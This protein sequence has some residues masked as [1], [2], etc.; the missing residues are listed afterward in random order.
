VQIQ[1]QGEFRGRKGR[2]REIPRGKYFR[3]LRFN[4]DF[5]FSRLGIKL[6]LD[7][8]K[9]IHKDYNAYIRADLHNKHNKMFDRIYSIINEVYAEIHEEDIGLGNPKKT[10]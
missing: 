4:E 1:F 8:V 10:K 3:S 6:L 7:A 2:K 5:D 9:E